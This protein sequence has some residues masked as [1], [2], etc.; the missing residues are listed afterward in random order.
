M[1]RTTPHF[2]E[3]LLKGQRC[4]DVALCILGHV[5]LAQ[6]NLLAESRR[7]SCH[8]VPGKGDEK[9]GEGP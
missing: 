1:Q 6:A 4:L 7:A 8:F 5:V 2:C 3:F 9:V